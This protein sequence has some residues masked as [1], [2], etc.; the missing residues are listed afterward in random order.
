MAHADSKTFGKVSR[1]SARN[2]WLVIGGWIVLLGV[3]NA[4]IPQL[5]VTVSKYS[6]PFLPTNLAATQTLREMST[7]F[8]VPQSASVGSVVLVDE[9]GL[10]A[11]D[12]ALYRQLI[13]SLRADHENVAYVLDT[14]SN[15]QLRDI[16]ISPD[17]KAINLLVAAT[18]DVGSTQAH[19]NVT[20]IRKTIE[21]MAKP[22][23]V[24]IYYTGF[25]PTLADLFTS[26]DRSLMIITGVSILLITML[27]LLVY[28]SLVLACIPLLTIGVS[29]GVTRP[30]ISLLGLSGTLTVSNFTIALMT[31]MVL[32]IGTDYAIF[33]LASYHEGRRAKLPAPAALQRAGEKIS[34]ILIASA[35][36][37]A[38]A[39]SAMVFTKIGMFK[40]AGPPTTIGVVITLAVSMTLPYALLSVAAQRGYAEPRILNERRWRRT[41]AR[42]IR[43][44][45]V[46]ATAS[47][48]V[49]IA[50]AAVLATLRLNFDENAMQLDSTDSTR[51][52][53]KVYAHWGVNE[54]A[55]EYLIIKSDHDMRNTNDL[56]ALDMIAT[57]LAKLPEVAVVRS[58]T[59]PSGKPVAETTIGHQVGIVGDRLTEAQQ[60]IQQSNPDLSRLT[61]GVDQLRDGANSANTQLPQ[62]ITGIGQVVSL[63]KGV[64]S[65]YDTASTALAT[66]TSNRVDVPRAIADLSS[67]VNLLDA[68]LQ[69]ISHNDLVA[70]TVS[71]ANSALAPLLSP[72]PAPDCIANPLC[73]RGRAAL[74]DLDASTN[75]SAVRSLRDL[76]ALTVE[77]QAAIDNARA[78]LP[79]LK[80]ALVQMQSL[81]KQLDGR[82]PTEVSAQLNQLVRGAEHL[83]GGMSQLATGLNRVK[84]GV[85]QVGTLTGPLGDGLKKASDYLD[86]VS[87][88]TSSGPGAGYYL[89]PQA[90][91]D[92]NFQAGEKL[93]FSADGKV[94]RMVVVWKV[95]PFSAE[96]RT[97]AMQLVSTSTMVAT[98]TTLEG[99]QITT[100]GVASIT[101]DMQHQVWRDFFT[102]GAVAILGIF[103]VM[104][105]LLRSIL[106][107]AFMVVMVTL[108]FASAAG[109]SVL[110][111]QHIVGIDLDFSV[112]PVSF[113]ALVAVGADYS[114]LFASRI[115]DESQDGMVRGILRGF[116]ST[117]SVITTAGIVFA[118]TMFALMSGSVIHLLQIGFTVGTG[119]LLDITVVRTILVPAAMTLIGNNIWWPQRSLKT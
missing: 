105:L 34:G 72:E 37:V 27:L 118:L 113:M 29:L 110:V 5:E 62:L 50:A 107:P 61:A 60:R 76:Q 6:A 89:P 57:N 18:G 36:T 47:L 106:A 41:G 28:R 40:A 111:W 108:S 68:A 1:F 67:S 12:H 74:A 99:A 16:A 101:T 4:A 49:L 22:Q 109:L 8:G 59:R 86:A 88:H 98:G 45:G 66:A 38:A 42:V 23:G 112:L 11:D 7:E 114:M 25:A 24:Q 79:G 26:M 102:F 48:V 30:I 73:M 64:L 20:E 44:S 103:L 75:G 70:A 43:H 54:A 39:A 119:L 92:K 58:I 78:A 52:Y 97:G 13:E 17:G 77:P 21:S 115:R 87:I 10:S 56:A 84:T 65:T 90:F 35:V 33:I 32:G 63:A 19:R 95:N 14:Y 100:T 96:A 71:T 3:L 46:L 116:T 80:G 51:G 9:H 55:P 104:A 31:A 69:A 15:D 53:E 2:A 94:T 82:P 93:L 83:A 85:D 81:S 117:G 91:S